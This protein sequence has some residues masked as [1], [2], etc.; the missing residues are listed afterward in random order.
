LTTSERASTNGPRRI[1]TEPRGC[2]NN[3]N[4]IV[5]VPEFDMI[6]YDLPPVRDSGGPLASC[7]GSCRVHKPLQT[8]AKLG[9][10]H[11]RA[12]GMNATHTAAEAL[13][14]LQIIAGEKVVPNSLNQYAL[15]SKAPRQTGG[16]RSAMEGGVDVFL[17]EICDDRQLLYGEIRF[18]VNY[19]AMGLVRPHGSALLAW[20]RQVCT[21]SVVDRQCVIAALEALEQGGHRCDEEIAD[22]LQGIRFE[23]QNVETIREDIGAMMSMAGGRWIVVGAVDVQGRDGDVMKNRRAL[24]AKVKDAADYCGAAFY[25]PSQLVVEH[26]P[27][28]AL[29]GGTNINEYAT[30]FYPTVGRTLANLTRHP[31]LPKETRI[32]ST[33]A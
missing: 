23:R 13:Q 10:V 30:N 28:V 3:P 17:V 6:I 29:R 1:D 19:V 15:G 20:F 18:Q 11:I 4:D 21:N 26:G 12:I 31:R 16:L 32:D 33:A 2:C 22:L 14:T 5:T 9:E 7:L 8:L 27:M 24:N 25:D